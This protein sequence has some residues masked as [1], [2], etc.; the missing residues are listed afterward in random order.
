MAVC[1]P[2]ILQYQQQLSTRGRLFWT[3][4]AR[5]SRYD[6]P[7]PT[8]L[9]MTARGSSSQRRSKV[10]ASDDP[11][12]TVTQHSHSVQ[13][14]GTVVQS[15]G[16]VVQSLGTVVQ[17][18]STVVQSLGTVV[19]SLSTVVQSLG[20]VVQSRGPRLLCVQV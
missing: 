5:C 17:S 11:H 3:S 2:P 8:A 19:Q 13:S 9:W 12:C 10:R 6:S 1:D 15:L 14:L 16:T 18:L 7:V 20:T 4:C